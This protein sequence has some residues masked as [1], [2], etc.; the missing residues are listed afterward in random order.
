MNHSA[1]HLMHQ[2]LRSILGTHVEQKGSMVHSGVFRFDFSHFTKVTS[3]EIKAVEKFVNARIQENI[4][5]E[6]GRK[7]TYQKAIKSGAIALF[8][9]KYGDTVRTIRFGQSIELCGGTH[10]ANTSDIWHFKITS[11]GAVACLLYT[12]DAADE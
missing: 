10:V 11:E 5:L 4:S 1:T 8:G 6:E 12:S 7:T 2:A 9:E 3:E